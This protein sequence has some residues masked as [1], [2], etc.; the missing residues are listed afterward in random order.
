MGQSTV[1]IYIS[2][3]LL[4]WILSPGRIIGGRN[5][6]DLDAGK[7]KGVQVEVLMESPVSGLR[8]WMNGNTIRGRVDLREGDQ[9]NG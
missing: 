7:G 8:N 4:G 9:A 6:Y 3:S 5:L 2:Q 1:V